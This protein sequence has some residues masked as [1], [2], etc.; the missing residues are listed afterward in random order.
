MLSVKQDYKRFNEIQHKS[1]SR[2]NDDEK[3]KADGICHLLSYIQM[4]ETTLK[5][6]PSNFLNK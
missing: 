4:G 2:L 1:Y 6:K 5:Y 3:V